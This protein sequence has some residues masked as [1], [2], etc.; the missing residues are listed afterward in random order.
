MFP[1]QHITATNPE[2]LGFGDHVCHSL[3]PSLVNPSY[4]NS[5]KFII[6]YGTILILLLYDQCDIQ[7]DF[8]IYINEFDLTRLFHCES[9]MLRLRALPW[10]ILV[11]GAPMRPTHQKK[12]SFHAHD[13]GWPKRVEMN[14][15]KLDAVISGGVSPLFAGLKSIFISSGW[16]LISDQP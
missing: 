10:L 7:S 8:V 5:S 6:Q 16:E 2:T 3:S 4:P 14:D 12:N 11:I 15:Q 9:D 13:G 1:R